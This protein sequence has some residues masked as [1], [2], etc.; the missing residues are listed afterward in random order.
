MGPD[1]VCDCAISCTYQGSKIA[2]VRSYLRVP[3]AAGQVKILI[4][5]V[6]FYFFLIY[7]NNF[8][9]AGQVPILRYFEACI[10]VCEADSHFGTHKFTICIQSLVHVLTS[11]VYRFLTKPTK[12][13]TECTGKTDQTWL[14]PC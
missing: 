9:D 4:F 5:P 14:R 13:P 10:L 3:Q 11:K 2:L 12:L 1:A 7:V 6:K 8:C